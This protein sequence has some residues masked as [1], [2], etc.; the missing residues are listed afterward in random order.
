MMIKANHKLNR[1]YEI[2]VLLSTFGVPGMRILGLEVKLCMSL[3]HT[4][5]EEE[6]QNA[7]EEGLS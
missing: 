3:W 7:N 4:A 2:H 1:W 6:C 5:T